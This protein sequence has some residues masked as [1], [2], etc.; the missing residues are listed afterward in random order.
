MKMLPKIVLLKM[1][2][3][4]KTI[5]GIVNEDWETY[6]GCQRETNP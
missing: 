6:L 1:L 2:L 4:V 3:C 5:F